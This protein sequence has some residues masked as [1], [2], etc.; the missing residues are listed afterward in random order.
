MTADWRRRQGA[1]STLRCEPNRP[2]FAL[3]NA[4]S[5]RYP[6]PDLFGH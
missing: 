2:L 5:S 6:Y 4:L 3:T 1:H